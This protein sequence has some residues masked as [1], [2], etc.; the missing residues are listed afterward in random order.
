M[1]RI[2]PE[3]EIKLFSLVDKVKE[4]LYTVGN[5]VPFFIS[6]GSVFSTMNGSKYD[7]IDVY[8]YHQNDF[9]NFRPLMNKF[10]IH[11][12]ANS[13]TFITPIINKVKFELDTFISAEGYQHNVEPY[14]CRGDIQLIKC[15]WGTPDEVFDTF[16]LNC[17]KC[18]ITSDYDIIR[19]S[20]WSENIVI[21]DK[22]A[23]TDILYRY[24]K[25]I[26][27]KNAQDP[28]QKELKRFLYYLISNPD[29]I[30]PA[31]YGT[32]P[33]QEPNVFSTIRFF[34]SIYQKK[35]IHQYIHDVICTLHNSDKKIEIFKILDNLQCRVCDEYQLNILLNKIELNYIKECVFTSED[36]RIQEKFAEYFI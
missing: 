33:K 18:C 2:T 27:Y 26:T 6:G 16:D 13:V 8:F 19:S 22:N 10:S 7:D 11:E 31:S 32:E 1:D 12:T 30:L 24:K 34:L 25:Y 23:K 17:S 3:I 35:D 5:E 14:Q 20:D 36:L 15:A 21:T 29:I 4:K 9:E 28:K